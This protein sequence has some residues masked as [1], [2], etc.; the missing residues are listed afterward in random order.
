MR[1]SS[2]R[3]KITLSASAQSI[4]ELVERISGGNQREFARTV[5]C[6]Q[7]VISRI[8]NGKQEPGREL[9]EKIAGLDGVDR[10]AL[11]ATLKSEMPGSHFSETL[12]SIAQCLLDGNPAT[13][14]DQLTTNTIAVSPT[15]FRPSLYAVAA[16]SCEP[17]F[18]DLSERMR[19]DDLLIIESSLDRLKKNLRMLDGKL[20]VVVIRGD[21]GDT[22]TLR[23]V[24][25]TF[26]PANSR[27]SARTCPDAKVDKFRNDKFEGKLLR[28][29]QLDLPESLPEPNYVDHLVD[30][31]DIAGVAIELIRNL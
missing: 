29:I 2:L 3:K 9:L 14:W 23:R 22:I 27:W 17:A 24:W 30:V 15:V 26:D 18:S 5:G 11:M 20:C 31:N 1:D 10:A 16:R 28:S 25:V 4:V 8:V 19:P 21:E 6:A 7:P 13:R 12:V